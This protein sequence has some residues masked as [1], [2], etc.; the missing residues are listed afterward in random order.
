MIK[1][2]IFDLDGVLVSTKEYHFNALNYALPK[3][4]QI[5][6]SEHI[7]TYDG[8][9]TKNKLNILHKIK[10]LPKKLFNEIIRKKDKKTLEFLQLNILPNKKLLKLFK[11]L[12]NENII[13][14]CASNAKR[15]TV[16]TC[17]KQLKII[18]Y[19]N[20]IYSNEDVEKPKPHFEIYFK[21]MFDNGFGPKETLIIEDSH[22]GRQAAYDTGAH[23]LALDYPENLNYELVRSKIELIE[24]NKTTIPWI[25]LDMNVLIPMAG[26]GS[27]F[28]NAGYTFPKPLIEIYNKPMIQVVIENLNLQANY[29][30][31]VRKEHYEKYNL[32][33][34]LNL[35]KPKC[36]IV[37]VDELTEGAAS[38]TLL[39][40][41]H[42]N[43]NKPLIIANSDQFVEWNSNEAMYS[44][45]QKGVDAGIVTFKSTHPKWSYAK[46]NKEGVVSKVAE[47]KPISD[48]ATVGIYYWSKGKDY[49][50][51]AEEM[52]QKNIRVN[53]EFYVCP[54]FNQL[55][56][57]KGKIKIHEV[58]KMWGL[59]TPED[60]NTFISS[61]K[62][63]F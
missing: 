34:L 63:N 37:I 39:A 15:E 41:K 32:K 54:V 17:L 36:K 51:C 20:V 22:I 21:C 6:L 42:I 57:R 33:L 13:I 62:N 49:V 30:F 10:K 40:K 12:K 7:S 2:I 60:L 58:N 14:S 29:I 16:I 11:N 46:L 9:P 59:G 25:D 35:I 24:K 47:K 55:I 27:R 44:F 8:L 56:E 45:S 5:K 61:N 1:H 50:S 38:T 48:N 52:I 18:K 19:F 23:L 26:E 31:L 3:K 28:A 4:F 53:N 43:N